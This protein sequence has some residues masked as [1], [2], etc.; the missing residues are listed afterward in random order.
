MGK[1]YDTLHCKFYLE[2]ARL[3]LRPQLPPDLIPQDFFFGDFS[4]EKYIRITYEAW[5]N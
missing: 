5:R 1:D 3:G 4:D 2:G